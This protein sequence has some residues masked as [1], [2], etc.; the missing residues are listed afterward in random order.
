MRRFD[1]QSTLDLT[2]NAPHTHNPHSTRVRCAIFDKELAIARGYLSAGE[3]SRVFWNC[4]PWKATCRS[5]VH[6]YCPLELSCTLNYR[7]IFLVLFPFQ[8]VAIC[9]LPRVYI[10]PTSHGQSSFR[11]LRGKLSAQINCPVNGE[12]IDL[13]RHLKCI[14]NTLLRLS[15]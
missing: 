14:G 3:N 7:F 13:P 11:Y 5:A 15:A 8:L 10:E 6:P 1:S 9:C 2:Q 4:A 12:C